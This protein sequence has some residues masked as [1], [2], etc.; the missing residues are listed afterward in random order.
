MQI[1]DC[2]KEVLYETLKPEEFEERNGVF[3]TIL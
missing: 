1:E 2:E 3:T